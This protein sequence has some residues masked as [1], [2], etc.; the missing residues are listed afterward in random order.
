MLSRAKSTSGGENAKRKITQIISFLLI[1][2]NLKTIFGWKLYDG[3][4]KKICVPVLNCHS[5]P[6][7]LSACPLGMLQQFLSLGIKNGMAGFLYILGMLGVPAVFLGRFFCGWACPFGFMQDIINVKKIT[8]FFPRVLKWIK[9]IL[10][11]GFVLIFPVVFTNSWGIGAPTFCKYICPAGTL[12]AG[13]YGAV[14]LKATHTLLDVKVLI[15]IMTVGLAIFVR[16]F[17][18]RICPLG[19][20]LGLFNKISLLQMRKNEK[21]DNC[22]NCAKVCPMGIDMPGNL[23]SINCI[24]CAKCVHACPEYVLKLSF[25]PEK[26]ERPAP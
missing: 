6:F 7:A 15:L 4:L 14:I 18:C 19:F 20:I 11:L 13:I 22:G 10:L 8:V 1:N 12:E 23:N 16:R 9:Y 5:C 25:L 3:P 2:G 26:P 24:R 21:C 17:F